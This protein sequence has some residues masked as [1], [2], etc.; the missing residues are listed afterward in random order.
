MART[1]DPTCFADAGQG[2]GVGARTR[3]VLQQGAVDNIPESIAQACEG[4][5]SAAPRVR[6]CRLVISCCE[7]PTER[8]PLGGDDYCQPARELR[9]NIADIFEG[10]GLELGAS[11]HACAEDGDCCSGNC[12]SDGVCGPDETD[13]I[14]VGGECTID[15]D[16]CTGW[17]YGGVCQTAIT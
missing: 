17:C 12:N 4:V 10:D 7:E 5:L 3:G 14:P 9:N 15:E 11:L 6:E 2:M 16:C 1:S 8:L 13:C